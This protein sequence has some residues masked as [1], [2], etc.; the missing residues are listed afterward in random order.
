MFCMNSMGN[1]PVEGFITSIWQHSKIFNSK[2]LTQNFFLIFRNVTLLSQNIIKLIPLRVSTLKYKKVYF[3]RAYV[4]IQGV[5]K[6]TT[7]FL[8]CPSKSQKS[9]KRQNNGFFDPKMTRRK[10]LEKK[11]RKINSI[12]FLQITKYTFS[13][14]FSQIL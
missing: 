13:E 4:I 3:L 8:K 10:K 6:V 7:P 9:Q 12:L 11:N 14:S 5:Q 1:G 2:F